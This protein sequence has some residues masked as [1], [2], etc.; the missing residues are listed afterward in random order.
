MR[1]LGDASRGELGVDEFAVDDCRRKLGG[2]SGDGCCVAGSMA[3]KV[4]R[5]AGCAATFYLAV[6]VRCR[7]RGGGHAA[8]LLDRVL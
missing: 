8:N 6:D 5:R 3:A 4:S 1:W 7:R 2:Y